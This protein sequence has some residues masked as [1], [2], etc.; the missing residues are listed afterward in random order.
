MTSLEQWV[1][2]LDSYPIT[3][4]DPKSRRQINIPLISQITEKIFVGGVHEG[5]ELPDFIDHVVSMAPWW[6]Y[7]LGPDQYRDEFQ[8]YDAEGDVNEEMLFAAV[9]SAVT[10]LDEGKTVL[11][12][13]QAGINRSNLVAS[14]V[15]MK[16][17]NIDAE[18]AISMLREKRDPYILSNRDFEAYVRSYQG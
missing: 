14:F 4:W 11:I 13:C 2:D 6:K 15:L 18:S 5:L 10:A 1:A 7:H 12:H 17:L 9:E 3:G 8:M 16:H